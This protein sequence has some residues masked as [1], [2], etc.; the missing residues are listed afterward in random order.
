MINDRKCDEFWNHCEIIDKHCWNF[1]SKGCSKK[2]NV[3]EQ[4]KC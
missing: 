2:I 4:H 1:S 3:C